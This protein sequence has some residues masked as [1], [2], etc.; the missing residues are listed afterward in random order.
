MTVC[1]VLLVP[2]HAQPSTARSRPANLPSSLVT[3][4]GKPTQRTGPTSSQKSTFFICIC[5][6]F[7]KLSLREHFGDSN[8]G[9]KRPER[10]LSPLLGR[11]H[12]LRQILSHYLLPAFHTA[13]P[14]PFKHVGTRATSPPPRLIYK[15]AAM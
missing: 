12:P 9:D 6:L 4:A 3:E 5:L 2:S 13:T 7:I 15:P 14:H 1:G 10:F 11:N 8:L